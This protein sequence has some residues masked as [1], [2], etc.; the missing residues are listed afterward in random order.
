VPRIFVTSLWVTDC[1]ITTDLSA[2]NTAGADLFL[3]LRPG[4]GP[5]FTD[6]A[7]VRRVVASVFASVHYDRDNET[8]QSP[9]V[10]P[11]RN[12]R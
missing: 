1:N 5:K 12:I 9:T 4:S 7:H 11:A 3:E 10:T 6:S 8:H 2:R